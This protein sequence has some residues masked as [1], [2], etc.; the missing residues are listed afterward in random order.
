MK[1][2]LLI[3]IVYSFVFCEDLKNETRTQF[4]PRKELKAENIPDKESLW[5]FIL[6][7]QSNMAGRGLVEPQDTI[8]SE[9]V[10]TINKDGEIIVAKEP[11]HFYEP[12]VR[13]L[14][15]GLSFGKTLSTKVPDSISILL[16]PT[17]VGGSSIS[18][19]LGDSIYR[20]VQLLTNFKEKV[21][22][23]KKFGQIKG[24]LWHQGESD[25]KPNRIPLYKDRLIHLFG[26]FREIAGN[27]NLPI[28]IGELPSFPRNHEN[29]MKINEQLRLY[30]S[31]DS[32]SDVIKV[33]DLQHKGDNVHFNSE[34]Q[35]ILGERYAN[36][37]IRIKK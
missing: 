37:Y 34:G 27:K 25:A 33:S 4:F 22:V 2:L 7:G 14:D 32:N 26:K 35:R 31:I 17:A 36:E 28:L 21:E 19:W 1:I 16:I 18:Q 23:G 30:S 12:S 8:P 13:G 11:L 24:I 9:R 10:L 20:Q 3:L 15:C 29:K 5:V 6:A